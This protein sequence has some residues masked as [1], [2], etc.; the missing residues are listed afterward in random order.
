M[1]TLDWLDGGPCTV[2]C[3]VCGE[4]GDGL[5]VAS[6]DDPRGALHTAS[7]CAV[8]GSV[9]ILDE[10]R[11]FAPDD[12]AVDAYVEVGAGIAVAA[13][14]LWKQRR[15]G[16]MS[17]LEV[18]CN[19][20]FGVD[21]SERVLG[22]SALGI[23]PSAAADRGCRELGVSIHHLMLTQDTVLGTK[24]DLVFASEVIEHVSDPVAFLQVMKAHTALGG[25]IFLTTPA[26]EEVTPRADPTSA[27]SALS[28][29]HHVF[30]CSRVGAE[31]L[32]SR[33]GFSTFVVEKVGGTLLICATSEQQLPTQL[34]GELPDDVI[35][36]YLK[37]LS[38]R[39]APNS[40]LRLGSS[41]RWLRSAVGATEWGEA[42]E[43][44]RAVIDVFRRRY[45]LDL[46]HPRRAVAKLPGSGPALWPLVGA[47][48][49]LAALT[50]H[51]GGRGSLR[52]AVEY[53][54]LCIEA[55]RRWVRGGVLFDR[56]L[57]NLWEA[58]AD[59]RVR[60]AARFDPVLASAFADDLVPPGIFADEQD[61]RDARISRLMMDL[62]GTG[63][64]E[65]AAAMADR[66]ELS[67]DRAAQSLLEGRAV[68]GR[69]GLY[70]VS[71]VRRSAGDIVGAERAL[72]RCLQLSTQAPGGQGQALAFLV[73]SDLKDLL[74]GS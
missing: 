37:Q 39:G 9:D 73:E 24:F 32:L 28:P 65:T 47:A 43:A 15:P 40:A 42:H 44:A 72:R 58:A 26:A 68:D 46:R 36:G 56:D 53:L 20:G 25:S 52:A 16:T 18:G 38:Q 51:Q 10:P 19:F 62:V 17:M 60:L 63:F 1:L 35:R 11:D 13:E 41:V 12:A 54:T 33:A 8:C 29:G 22:W 27:L 74:D 66:V 7:R 49:A 71:V 21:F 67:A 69:D 59:H 6:F 3:R 34:G 50:E 23:E 30:L 45:K 2:N 48:Y 57:I 55:E 70:A 4:T 61:R 31:M 64:D 14:R 5:L